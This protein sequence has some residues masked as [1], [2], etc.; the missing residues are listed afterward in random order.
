MNRKQLGMVLLAML[1]AAEPAVA[2]DLIKSLKGLFSE[3]ASAPSVAQEDLTGTD[4]QLI[5][6]QAPRIEPV[7][8]VND[9]FVW[10]YGQVYKE[11]LWKHGDSVTAVAFS[12]DGGRVLTGSADSTVV[13]RDSQ[14]GKT[15]RT[16]KHENSV[17]AVA[18]SPDGSRVLT[19]SADNS[20][21]LRDAQSGKTLRTWKH[22]N[23]VTAVAFSPDGSRVLTGAL[24]KSVVLRDVNSG[25]SLRT[26]KH[27]PRRPQSGAKLTT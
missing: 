8:V 18:F 9:R 16:W 12:P 24:D 19:G 11:A 14:S 22:E 10:S 2:F 5:D 6:D 23:S 20:V 26:W 3:D 15:L 7:S 13:L 17:T 21:V 25:Q 4:S 1:L 27:C